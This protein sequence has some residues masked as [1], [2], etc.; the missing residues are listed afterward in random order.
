MTS[1]HDDLYHAICAY[2]DEDTPRLAF[3]DLLD[4]EGDPLR[5]EFIRTQVELA[6]VPE[7]DPLWVK[8]RQFDPNAILGH[9]MAH[10]L[11][12]LPADGVFWGSPASLGFRRGFPWFVRVER[13]PVFATHAPAVF[14]LAPVR[15]A[16]VSSRA[17]ISRL[18]DCAHLA[19]LTRLECSDTRLDGEAATRL[20]N[21]EHGTNLTELSFEQDGIEP[22][23][24]RALI[25]S[26][27]FPRLAALELKSNVILQA[28]LLIDALGAA[29]EPGTLRSL[30]I[31]R[32]GVTRH[33]AAN[34]FELPVLRE[35]DHLDLSGNVLNAGGMQALADS[36]VTGWLRVLNLSGTRPGVAGVRALTA[37]K[38]RLA[39]LRSLD[40][41]DNGLGPVA[42]ELLAEAAGLRKLRVL[43]L[44]G[45]PVGDAGAAALANSRHLSELLELDLGDA[46]VGD[47]GAQ[48]LAESPHLGNLLRLNLRCRKAGRS[49]GTAARRALRERFG[50]RVSC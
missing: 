20:G 32:C 35:L 46:G 3:A 21:S 45:N 29:D 18:A 24:L 14:E 31:P 50:A 6:K 11:R 12:P 42:V 4:E 8:C 15:A 22:D 41:S 37:E 33:D 5:A 49:L 47:A 48:A 7:Y 44:S 36:R 25:E 40:V 1:Q 38:S 10:T 23:G 17:G 34:L 28:E 43:N 39:R 2:P 19:R 27:L 26:P 30:A 16:H 13:F 9:G